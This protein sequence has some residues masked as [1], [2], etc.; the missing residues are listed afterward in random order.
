MKDRAE[1]SFLYLEV[2]FVC[3]KIGDYYV[4]CNVLR[5]GASKACELKQKSQFKKYLNRLIK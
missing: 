2:D 3:S 1:P 5:Q 4:Q